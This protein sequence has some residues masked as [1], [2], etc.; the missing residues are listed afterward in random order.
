MQGFSTDLIYI[1]VAY[2]LLQRCLTQYSTQ[3]LSS[4]QA[5][6]HFCRLG[7]KRVAFAR[8]CRPET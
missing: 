6:R 8:L 3:Q 7:L 4:A 5:E 1:S 2:S